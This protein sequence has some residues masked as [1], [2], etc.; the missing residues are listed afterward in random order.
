MHRI[1]SVL[2][3]GDRGWNFCNSYLFRLHP[4]SGQH[5][6]YLGLQASVIFSN[7]P[8]YWRYIVILLCALCTPLLTLYSTSGG[9]IYH[10][11][12]FLP[13]PWLESVR[14]AVVLHCHSAS[15]YRCTWS[16]GSFGK[17]CLCFAPQDKVGW[18][19]TPEGKI[20]QCG[21][22]TA[23]CFRGKKLQKQNWGFL[24]MH[25]LNWCIR[26]FFHLM[27]ACFCSSSCF[28]FSSIRCARL[29]FWMSI[30]VPG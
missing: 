7:I 5:S 8:P 21:E 13:K 2:L 27:K 29:L 4:A 14:Q 28:Y 26:G 16:A 22:A 9:H 17:H 6:L 18:V 24:L 15:P 11:N 23:N 30:I 20:L 19:Q 3:A 10:F 12:Y 25:W 1:G